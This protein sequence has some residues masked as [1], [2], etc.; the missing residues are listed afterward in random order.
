[1]LSNTKIIAKTTVKPA[2]TLIVEQIKEP[3]LRK[4]VRKDT[5]EKR[6]KWIVNQVNNNT[7]FGQ[8]LKKDYE[9]VIGKK[10]KNILDDKAGG[11]NKHYDIVITH[12]DESVYHCEEKGTNKKR[13]INKLKNPWEYAVQIFNGPAKKFTVF[14]LKYAELW[15][16]IILLDT[17]IRDKY[18]I[19]S[20]L[21][22]K[23]TWI[24]QD[25]FNQGDPKT[26]Y[27]KEFKLKFREKNGKRTSMT[28]KKCL[29]DN[30]DY[31]KRVNPLYIEYFQNNIEIQEE[32]IKIIQNMLNKVLEEKDCWLQCT[33]MIPDINYKWYKKTDSPVILDV[34]IDKTKSDIVFVCN[35]NNSNIKIE[36][37]LRFG[38]GCGFSN[39]RCDI[40]LK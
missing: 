39:L 9:Q 12:T 15:Y 35:T 33:G 5:E 13:D 25:L 27:G 14:T 36:C 32:F 18:N 7:Q 26:P 23:E 30:I 1:M 37:I 40:K 20:N 21:P 19:Q 31:R 11:R 4:D 34:E 6:I 16:D 28:G 8:Q 2:V 29:F 24:K 10:I 22:S 3:I 17:T 38:K